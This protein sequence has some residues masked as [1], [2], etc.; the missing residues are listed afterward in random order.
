[1]KNRPI[2]FYNRDQVRT[3]LVKEAIKGVDLAM[4]TLKTI[5]QFKMSVV[6]VDI[7]TI[8]NAV[9]ICLTNICAGC[10]S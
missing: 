4:V 7:V 9:K 8:G 5:L 10:N 6:T 1:M 2:S 3:I